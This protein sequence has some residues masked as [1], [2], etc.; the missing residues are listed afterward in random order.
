[1]ATIRQKLGR[2]KLAKSATADRSAAAAAL[3]VIG[4]HPT[5]GDQGSAHA[6]APYAGSSPAPPPPPPPPRSGAEPTCAT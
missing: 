5:D 4:A 6:R 1:M 3:N 2:S